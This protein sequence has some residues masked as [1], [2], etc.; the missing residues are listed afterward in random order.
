MSVNDAIK[1]DVIDHAAMVRLLEERL[2]KDIDGIFVRYQSRLKSAVVNG[3]NTRDVIRR[4]DREV[5]R[6]IDRSYGMLSQ[7]LRTFISMEADFHTD[8]LDREVGDIWR[9]RNTPKTPLR[10]LIATQPLR[11][12]RVLAEHFRDIGAGERMRITSAIRRGIA[13][14]TPIEEIASGISTKRIAQHQA[15]AIVRTAITQYGTSAALDIYDSN[16]GLLKGYQYVATLDSRTTP[17]CSRNDGRVFRL[18]DPNAPRP[19][20]HWNCRSTT[21]PVTKAFADI[22]GDQV[23]KGAYDNASPRMRASINGQVPVVENYGTWLMRQPYEV[24]LRHLGDATRV[25]IFKQGNLKLRQFTNPAGRFISLEVL[26]RLN[27]YATQRRNPDQ[28]LLRIACD[29]P[30]KNFND[31][32]DFEIAVPARVPLTPEDFYDS[33]DA[34]ALTTAALRKLQAEYNIGGTKFNDIDFKGRTSDTRRSNRN[35]YQT[36]TTYQNGYYDEFGQWQSS[37]LQN[38]SRI[39]EVEA[40]ILRLIADDDLLTDADKEWLRQFFARSELLVGKTA[41]LASLSAWRSTFRTLRGNKDNSVAQGKNTIDDLWKANLIKTNTGAIDDISK[42]L[43]ATTTRGER[44]LESLRKDTIALHG[45]DM[46]SIP[47]IIKEYPNS[48]RRVMNFVFP[49]RP[50]ARAFEFVRD[51]QQKPE[52]LKGVT[53][54]QIQDALTEAV[55]EGTS[56]WTTLAVRVGRQLYRDRGPEV[57]PGRTDVGTP[58]QYWEAGDIIL[59]GLAENGYLNKIVLSARKQR[60]LDEE[61]IQS[62]TNAIT[63]RENL[64]W[65]YPE[66]NR[67]IRD[68]QIIQVRD[69]LGYDDDAFKLTAKTGEVYYLDADGNPTN[70]SVRSRGKQKD[71]NGIGPKTAEALNAK[72]AREYRVEAGGMAIIR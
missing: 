56:D 45:G 15:R 5:R 48:Q 8:L 64:S 52:I 20:L 46:L 25:D 35:K 61:F 32:D 22:D 63:T 58:M 66:V 71:H 50:S 6:L 41:A 53:Q 38:V 2:Q 19:P 21:V 4:A 68:Q 3:R 16:E 26:R 55:R 72:N 43:V 9:T 11:D 59:D 37:Y 18:D 24:Q 51:R 36:D 13:S 57:F 40:D 69:S 29:S 10:N 39:D 54:Q 31:P 44:D 1:D 34:K 7:E 14:G 17:I 33:V 28:A 60:Q 67:H 62:G 30:C 12:S 23:K 27:A 65:N 49:S 70:L 42:R 47:A